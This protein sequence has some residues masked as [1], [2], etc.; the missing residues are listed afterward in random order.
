M[1]ALSILPLLSVWRLLHHLRA[2]CPPCRLRNRHSY[3]L[4][5]MFPGRRLSLVICLQALPLLWLNNWLWY[6]PWHRPI[7]SLRLL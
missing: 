4:C 3:K 6:L 2:P 7:F 1:D 5:W